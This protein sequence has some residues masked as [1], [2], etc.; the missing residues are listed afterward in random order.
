MKSSEIIFIADY[1][2]ENFLGGAEMANEELV[3]L[4]RSSGNTVEKILC[5]NVTP[6]F[7][8]SNKDKYFIVSNFMTLGGNDHLPGKSAR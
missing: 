2:L 8:S 5:Q 7:I 6:E 1:F 4:L 3:S